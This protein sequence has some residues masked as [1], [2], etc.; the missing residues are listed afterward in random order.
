M[1][2]QYYGNQFFRVQF[3]DTVLAF[4]PISK[5]SSAK[6]SSFGADIVLV[7]ADHEDLNGVD[8][9]SRGDREPF[10]IDGPGEYEV[11]GIVVHGFGTHTQYGGGSI[12]TIYTVNLEGMNLCH[13]GALSN[14]DLPSDI[15]G[16]LG[17]VDILFVPIGGDGLLSPAQ[18]HKLGV[19]LEARLIIPMQ[20]D[21]KELKAF[22]K[23]EGETNGKPTDKL[24]I[25]SKDIG[26]HSGD[27]VVL[28]PQNK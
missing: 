2:I 1:I 4:N 9:V 3:G 23:E 5:K 12:N 21:D 10:I 16:E 19:A 22:L 17:D 8:V 20:Y 28:A 13:L 14:A 7:S 11:E 26:G 18:A 27:I 24:T 25:R 6:S 15:K